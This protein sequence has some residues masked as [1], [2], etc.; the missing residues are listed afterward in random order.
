MEGWQHVIVK[1]TVEKVGQIDITCNIA[2]SLYSVISLQ[3]K[4]SLSFKSLTLPL[5]DDQDIV[6]KAVK[7]IF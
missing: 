5:C 7:H 2:F 6:V 1:Y 4:I 3:T